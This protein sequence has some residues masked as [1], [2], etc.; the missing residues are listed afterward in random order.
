MRFNLEEFKEEQIRLARK[1][2]TKDD[3]E[4]INLIAGVDQAFFENKIISAI[5]VLEYPSMKLV[6]EKYA[7]VEA[8]I[9][10]IPGY[11]GFRESPAVLEAFTKLEHRPQLLIVDGHGICHPRKLGIASQLGLMLDIPTIGVAKKPL[12]GEVKD[13]KVYVEDELRGRLV[14]TREHANPLI[15]SIGHRISLKTAMEIVEKST[16]PPHKLPEPL[17]IAHRYADKVREEEIKSKEIK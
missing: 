11:L 12:V 8:Q 15:V 10:Y 13:D 2:I 3:F 1:I 17:H 16:I 4:E 9:P 6:E 5:A 7:V 14:K